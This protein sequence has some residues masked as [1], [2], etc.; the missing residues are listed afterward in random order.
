MPM[1]RLLGLATSLV[2]I[3][4]CGETPTTPQPLDDLGPSF[5]TA[6]QGNGALVDHF[7]D[8]GLTVL[9]IDTDNDLYSAQYTNSDQ[10]AAFLGCPVPEFSGALDAVS[11]QLPNGKTQQRIIGDVYVFL[12]AAS[13]FP[14]NLCDEPI[15]EGIVHLQLAL[16][17][18]PEGSSGVQ[19]AN[20]VSNGE[21]TLNADGSP[22]RFHQKRDGLAAP[23]GTVRIH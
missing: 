9:T 5:A 19:D 6:G 15:A 20:V 22:V 3:A 16:H 8:D 11:V 17:L 14:F 1:P 4:G 2:V 18:V 12:N 7:D 13:G 23:F 10:L 21:I